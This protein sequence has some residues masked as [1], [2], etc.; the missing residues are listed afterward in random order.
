MSFSPSFA[1]RVAACSVIVAIASSDPC[2]A[3]ARFQ[4][5]SVSDSG[6]EANGFLNTPVVVLSA[7][8]RHV[9]FDSYATNL[10]PWDINTYP[11]VFVRDRANGTTILISAALTGLTGNNV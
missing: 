10:S 9:A 11:D 6:A 1:A 8:G 5:I 4:R 2:R 7:D 3:Q